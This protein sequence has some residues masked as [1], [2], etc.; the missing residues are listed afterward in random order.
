V[1]S[2]ELNEQC[3]N[4]AN[5][6]TVPTTSISNL[7]GVNVILAIWF[8]ECKCGESFYDAVACLWASKTLQQLLEYKASA[9]H[10][11]CSEESVAQRDNF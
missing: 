6:N 10:L 5:L 4:G 9:K 7:R 2:A 8:D 11:I 1:S 3:V